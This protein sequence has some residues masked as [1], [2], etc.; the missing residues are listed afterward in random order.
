LK[1]IA[2]ALLLIIIMMSLTGCGLPGDP[3]LDDFYTR[4][5]YPGTANTYTIGSEEYPYSEGWFEDL[6]VAGD[7]AIV[8]I[9]AVEGD[10]VTGSDILPGGQL[11]LTNE[12]PVTLEG[13]AR[14]WIEFRPELDFDIVKKN[15]VP[16]SYVRGMLSGFELPIWAADDEELF[17]D[18]CIPNR[19][20][21]TSTSHIHLD[22]FLIDA[23][24]DG[25]DFRLQI[26]YEHYTP[27]IDVVPL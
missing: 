27:G 15:A 24:D 5:V 12:P 26:A 3:V 2:T 16:L 10:V 7:G 6:L 8:G 11:I 23:Q 13:D 17:F 9:L 1:R 19:W 21:R 18:I 25:D 4:N 14:V 22:C 20:D